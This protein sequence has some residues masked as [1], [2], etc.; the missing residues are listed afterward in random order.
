MVIMVLKEF[1]DDKKGKNRFKDSI[2]HDRLIP[3]R[4]GQTEEISK[5]FFHPR[6]RSLIQKKNLNFW[7][8]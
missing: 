6:L 7:K 2:V 1:L 5:F 4:Q 3:A 8:H